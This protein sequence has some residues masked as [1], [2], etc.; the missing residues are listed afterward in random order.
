MKFRAKAPRRS[1]TCYCIHVARLPA[2]SIHWRTRERELY[3]RR[4]RSYVAAELRAS[5][6]QSGCVRGSRGPSDPRA[7]LHAGREAQAHLDRR[8]ERARSPPSSSR[9]WSTGCPCR[10]RS[11]P[12]STGPLSVSSR[13]P[14]SVSARSCSTASPSTPGSSKSSRTP[15]AASRTT[16]GC[17]RCSS[18]SRSA[19]SSKARPVSARRSRWPERCWR[20]SVSPLSMPPASVCWQTRRR[21]RL[22]PSASQ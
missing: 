5:R 1:G 21:L 17:R 2:Q 22:D 7:V 12:C 19:L 16:V 10:W 11:H 4:S 3:C 18:P 9:S 20:A 8:D 14:G 15:S 13:S 6:R